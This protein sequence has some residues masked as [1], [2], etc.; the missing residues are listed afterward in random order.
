MRLFTLLFITMQLVPAFSQKSKEPLVVSGTV[1]LN[2]K[3]ALNA[4]VLVAALK[5]DWKVKADSLNVAD[6]TIVFNTPTASV[7]I[8]QLDYVADPIEIRAASRLSWLWPTAETEALKH[9]SQ[10]VISVIGADDK[11]L[12]LHTLFTKIAAVILEKNN[13][14]GVYMNSQYLLVSKGFYTSAAHN[15]LENQSLPLY[16]WVYFGRPGDGGAYTYGMSEFGVKEMEI[17][18]SLKPEPDVHSTLYDA[19]Y[20]VLKYNNRLADGQSVITEEGQKIP[21]KLVRSV[22]LE[23]TDVVRLEY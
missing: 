5:T 18:K 22:F 13:A 19:A 17:A 8:A 6:K 23:A 15:M 14:S 21:V 10:V 12:E 2:N 7:M 9:Q 1:L 20:A 11:S 4:S 3:D 16:C